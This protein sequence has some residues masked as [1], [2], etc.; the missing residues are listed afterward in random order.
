ME[1]WP[2]CD[3]LIAFH[4]SGFPLKKSIDYAKL[5]QPFIINN[6]AAQFNIQG[7]GIIRD[8]VYYS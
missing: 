1:D 8:L 6:L 3:C 5:R 4:S 7:G 2:A